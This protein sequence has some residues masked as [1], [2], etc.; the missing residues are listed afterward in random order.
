M[1]GDRLSGSST[2]MSTAPRHL[3]TFDFVSGQLAL[4]FANT[5]GDRRRPESDKLRAYED[6][7]AFATQSQSLPRAAARRLA[8][9]ARRQPAAAAAALAAARALRDSLYELLA[10]LAAGRRLPTGPL[11]RFNAALPAALARLRL[12][13]RPPGLEWDWTDPGVPL[14]A[15]QWPALGAAAEL[16]TSPAAARV[17]ECASETCTWLFLDRSRNGSRRWCDMKGCGNRAKAR[18]HYRRR[19]AAAQPATA[20]R[21][22]SLPP[23]RRRR[24]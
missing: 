14:E 22:A 15:P 8:Q 16:L 18:R 7:L 3:P 23:S 9:R 24:P 4:D 12:A 6:L 13:A 5:W 2:S 20:P 10:A 21:G 19:R 17:R 1:P 11:A